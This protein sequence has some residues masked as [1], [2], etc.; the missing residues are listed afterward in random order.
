ML[1]FNTAFTCIENFEWWLIY[2]SNVA[3]RNIIILVMKR[4]MTIIICQILLVKKTPTTRNIIFVT[5][6]FE[7]YVDVKCGNYFLIGT[8][9]LIRLDF[10]QIEMETIVWP[11]DNT[12]I[13][14]WQETFFFTHGWTN[15]LMDIKYFFKNIVILIRLWSQFDFQTFN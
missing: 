13:W 4:V 9:F 15:E 3:C 6:G 10:L 7:H 11:I 2:F 12:Q 5:N 1:N 14:W 8:W